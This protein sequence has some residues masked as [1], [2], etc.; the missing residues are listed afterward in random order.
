MILLDNADHY[1]FFQRALELDF[2]LFT[3]INREWTNSFFDHV[4]PFLRES[5][6]WLPFYLFLL[7]FALLNYSKQGGWWCVTLGM[8]AIISD[9]ISSSIIKPWV[10]RLRPCMDPVISPYVRM[11]AKYCPE[12]GSFTSSH[13]CNHLSAAVFIFLTLRHTSNWW[14]LVFVWAFAISYAQIYVGVHY[15]TD[16]IGG[17]VLGGVIGFLMSLFF[18]K[19]FGLLKKINITV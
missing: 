9:L 7:V 4:L 3:K 6:I 11:L 1:R 17:F 14:G 19:N 16:I 5:E 10:G 12:N 18:K 2:G 8:T 13:A 15:P